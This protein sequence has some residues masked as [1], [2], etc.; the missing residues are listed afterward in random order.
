LCN[1]VEHKI[2]HGSIR[3]KAHGVI[4]TQGRYPTQDPFLRAFKPVRQR[5]HATL[6]P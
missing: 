3:F 2:Q 6:P 1:G 4:L 5:T